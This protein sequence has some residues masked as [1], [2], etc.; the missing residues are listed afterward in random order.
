MKFNE[1]LYDSRFRVL[2]SEYDV[3]SISLSGLYVGDLLSI[4]MSKAKPGQIWL[5]IQ[6]HPNI[7]AVAAL[8]E[9][10]AVIVVEGIEVPTETI[11]MANEKGV[12]L[13]SSVLDAV[14][15]IKMIDL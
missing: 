5:T 2:N 8:I 1:I 4:V 3:D 7:I 13:I 6:T 10:S 14:E 12:L 15:I 11:H 9:L